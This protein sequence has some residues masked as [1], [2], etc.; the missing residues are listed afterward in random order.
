MR[1][2]GPLEFAVV[3]DLASEAE[4]LVGCAHPGLVSMTRIASSQVGRGPYAY[5]SCP[6]SAYPVTQLA[7]TR[8]RHPLQRFRARTTIARLTP[9]CAPDCSR[10]SLGHRS[11][12]YPDY[13]LHQDGTK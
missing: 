7:V 8:L 9:A 4:R 10:S 2:C 13:V 1:R 6:T 5:W 12:V 3:Q 11:R